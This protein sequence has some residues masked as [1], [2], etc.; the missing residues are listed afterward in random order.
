MKFYFD[1]IVTFVTN[2]ICNMKNVT[3]LH[4]KLLHLGLLV[5]AVYIGEKI[6]YHK[7]C[8]RLN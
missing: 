4:L 5:G 6:L 7:M 8:I 1:N 3:M 2:V